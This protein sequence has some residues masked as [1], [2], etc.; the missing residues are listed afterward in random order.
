MVFLLFLIF[1]IYS[2]VA[3]F[4]KRERFYCLMFVLGFGILILLIPMWQLKV[5]DFKI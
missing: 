3:I 2:G 1:V 4:V 5:L